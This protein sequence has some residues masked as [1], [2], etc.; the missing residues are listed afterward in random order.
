M[1]TITENSISLKV[2]PNVPTYR[3]S[4]KTIFKPITK[5]HNRFFFWISVINWLIIIAL[6]V[7]LLANSKIINA[8]LDDSVENLI[9]NNQVIL[10]GMFI[11]FIVSSVINQRFY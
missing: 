4:L 7:N 10:A 11:S 1:N 9:I 5:K 2:I 6:L 3:E 8:L